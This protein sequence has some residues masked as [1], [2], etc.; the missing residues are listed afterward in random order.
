MH[1]LAKFKGAARTH[2]NAKGIR[3][4][5]ERGSRRTDN[6]VKLTD[7][8]GNPLLALYV[9]VS[10]QSHGSCGHF[11]GVNAKQVNALKR[12]GY[13]WYLFLLAGNQEVI[14]ECTQRAIEPR[15]DHSTSPRPTGLRTFFG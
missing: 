9:K 5:Q 2:C 11:W 6:V 4:D 7:N 8:H 14:K 10:T 12:K 1:E 15:H 13:P 3:L